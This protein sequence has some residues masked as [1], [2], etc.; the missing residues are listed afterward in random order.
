MRFAAISLLVPV[1]VLAGCASS[2]AAPERPP[3]STVQTTLVD[4]NGDGVLEAGPGE[5][6]VARTELAPAGRIRR[7]I[8][9]FAQISDLHVVDEESPLRVEPL[10]RLGGSVRSAFRP[11][12]ALS[13]QVLAAT[14]ASI[15]DQ[16]PSLLLATG[17]L[18]DN[19]QLDELQWALATLRGGRV[20]PDSGR[21]GYDG[22]QQAA[23]ADPFLYRPA[24]DAPRHPGL[25]TQ[26]QAA[27]TSPGAAMPYLLFPSN[28]DLLV[29]GNLHVDARLRSLAT[30]TRKLVEPAPWVLEAARTGTLGLDSV[31]QA[32][33]APGRERDVPA[34][35]AR[36]PFEPAE[37]LA[38]LARADAAELTDGYL[39]LD[40]PLAPGVRLLTLDT[41]SRVRGSDGELPESE[42]VWLARKLQEHATDRIVV[43]SPTPLE[44]TRGGDRAFALLDAR[45]GVLAVIA[46]D[47][48]RNA[49]SPHASAHGGYWLVRASSLADFPQQARMYRIV[50]LDDGRIALQTWVV[51]QAGSTSAHGWLGLAGISRDL[52]FLDSQGGRPLHERGTRLDRNATLFLP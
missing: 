11:Q 38:E 30:G 10:D 31:E 32:L 26:A 25:L 18:V 17:D 34:D 14:L 35:P 29:Q 36:R 6:L 9:T 8:T 42:L 52:A 1:L 47:T 13:T 40:R 16:H 50:E 24:V 46:G 15:N 5:A 37:M 33:A 20:H 28:H 44:N 27:F 2:A 41:S 48:H 49:I 45:P 43:M 22:L 3:G 51:D 7:T 23:S 4:R 12:E 39:L 19:A 21:A